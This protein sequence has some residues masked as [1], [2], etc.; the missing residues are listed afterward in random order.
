[1]I[2]PKNLSDRDFIFEPA[3]QHNLII[4]AYII[5][6]N[7]AGVIIKNKTNYAMQILKKL[8]LRILQ[9][10]DYENVFFA[11]SSSN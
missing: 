3:K 10:V 11:K 6:I 1:M 8:H 7:I 9:E 2:T 4:Y 5:D